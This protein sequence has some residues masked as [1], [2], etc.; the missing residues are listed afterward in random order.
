M[1]SNYNEQ[2]RL[3]RSRDTGELNFSLM[4]ALGRFKSRKCLGLCGR[5]LRVE[6]FTG[7][8]NKTNKQ[9]NK[10]RLNTAKGITLPKTHPFLCRPKEG[11]LGN[12]Q[13]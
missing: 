6:G 11:G 2:T 12:R 10:G 13:L 1:K 4:F 8:L 7:W 5:E 9:T 3:P